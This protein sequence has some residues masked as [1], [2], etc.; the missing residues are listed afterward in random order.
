MREEK[1]RKD[2]K[3]ALATSEPLYAIAQPKLL[4]IYD[5]KTS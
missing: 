5:D 2:N 3:Y 4:L 1:R